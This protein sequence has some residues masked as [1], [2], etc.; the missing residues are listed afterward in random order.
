[1]AALVLAAAA[2]LGLAFGPTHAALW[3]VAVGLGVAF[4]HS[5]FGFTGTYRAL[6]ARGETVG[7]RAQ[8]LLIALTA[9]LFAAAF[10]LVPGVRGFVF[11]AGL[12][13]VLGAFLF[14]IGM[15]LG[16]GCG[17]GC[18][19]AAGG[20]ETR[21]WITLVAFVAGGTLAAWQWPLWRDW[22]AL[23]PLSLADAAGAWPALAGTLALLGALY[24]AAR[25]PTPIGGRG[26]LLRGPW[27]QFWGV[28]AIAG[29]SLATLL[30]A[31]RPWGI[32][33]A[34]PLWGSR[35]IEFAG[36]DDPTFWPWWEDPTRTETF[37]A[38]ILAD[39]I[40]VMDLGVIAGAFL[41][42]RLARRPGFTRVRAG[43]VAASLLGGLLLGIGAI[44][45]TGCNIS[46][47]LAGIASFSLH[48]WAWAPPALLGNAVGVRLRPLFG[49]N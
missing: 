10:A 29:L 17:S 5:G 31:G 44:M 38:P 1:M 4:L 11:P 21:I 15:Q 45:A 48:G 40:T 2:A 18:L 35:A 41:A 16:G 34:F 36:L 22:P 37:L 13:L 7:V 39:R 30:L 3:L 46:A 12:A 49:L 43:E 20:G 24:L 25:G 9:T 28:V 33:A 23:P 19:Y 6:F 32:T 8:L 42:A 47:L 27:P 14:G 26:S